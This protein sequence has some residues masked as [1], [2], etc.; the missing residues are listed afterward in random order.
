MHAC[1][2][3][4]FACL[5]HRGIKGSDHFKA[6]AIKINAFFEADDNSLQSGAGQSIISNEAENAV[7]I[8]KE[9][10]YRWPPNGKVWNFSSIRMARYIDKIM[11]LAQAPKPCHMR[12]CQ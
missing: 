5:G 8:G 7:G 10:R 2:L 12:A 4:L 3:Q 1:Q 6:G 9:Q 11:A